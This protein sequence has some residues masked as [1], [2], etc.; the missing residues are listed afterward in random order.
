MWPWKT[1]PPKRARRIS[2]A[3]VERRRL[4]SKG[5][6][7]PL[8]TILLTLSLA[9][10]GAPHALAQSGISVESSEAVVAF[11]QSI[12]FRATFASSSPITEVILFYGREGEPLVRRIYP[13]FAPGT[14]VSVSYVE[15]LESGQFPPGAQLRVYWSVRAQDGTT[16]TTPATRLEHADDRF[17]WQVLTAKDVELRWYGDQREQNRALDL[18]RHAEE[19]LQ[20]LQDEMGVVADQ[21]VT[22]YVY[23]T[24][25]DMAPALGTRSEGYDEMIMTLGVAMDGATLLLLGSHG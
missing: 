22:I 21:R 2:N 14:R 8:V 16:L 1:F 5:R 25:R 17:T 6:W 23:N 9:L 24:Q 3:R 11:G 20:R 13:T 15:E 19:V 18:L 10:G 12:T 7:S 4:A